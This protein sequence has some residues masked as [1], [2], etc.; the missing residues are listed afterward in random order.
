[1]NR[2][3][4]QS[5][6]PTVNKA[7]KPRTAWWLP[8]GVALA[9]GAAGAAQSARPPALPTTAVEREHAWAVHQE[10]RRDSPF[11]ALEWRAVGPKMVGGR[12]EA[13]AV[14][15]DNPATIYAGGAGNL[16]KTVN[17]G[18][19]WTPV[20]EHQEAFAIGDVAVA[21][22]NSDVVW[23]G[24]GE[25]Q[26]RFA[27][28]AFSGTGVYK[29]TDGGATWHNM[30]L[31]DT[32]HIPKVLIDPRNP[33]I[34][35]VS[36]MGHQ[37]STNAERG[38]FKTTD[39]G[40]TWTKVLYIDDSTGVIDMAM[41]PS[42]SAIVYAAAWHLPSG[43]QSAIYKTI[44]GG[45]TWKKLTNG[46][47]KGPLGRMG[48]DVAPGRPSVLYAFL[49]N[50]AKYEGAE[51]S[52]GR[53]VIGAELYRTDD[54]GEHWRRVNET[55]LYE[56]FTI[57]GWKFCDVRVSSDNPDDVYILGN[58]GYH[59]TDGGRTFSPFGEQILRLHDTEGKVL[60]LDQHEIWID[61]RNPNRVIVGNDGGL[62]MSYDRAH[63]WLHMNNLPI[64]QFY[65]VAT[66]MQQPYVIYGGTQ[67]DAAVYGPSDV[68]IAD[69]AA[70]L[71]HHV[72]L[73][74]WTGG[75]SFVTLPDPTDPNIVYYEHQNGDLRRMDITGSSVQT[76]RAAD[77]RPRAA[78]GEPEWRFGWYMPFV[79]S[80][81]NRE[82]LYAG[83]NKL[84]MSLDRGDHWQAISPDLSEPAG[85]DRAVV[86]YGTITMIGESSVKPGL[87]YVGTE[88]GAV[89]LTKNNGATWT[90]V[91]GDLPRKWVTRVIPSRWN[92]ATVYVGMSGYRTDDFRPYLYVSRDFGTTWR[93]IAANLPAESINVV[94]EDP[95]NPNVLY[96]GTDL[97]VYAS[98]D[99]G[100]SWVSLA[101][102]LPSTPVEDLVVHPRD[103]EIVIGTHGRG[104]F[105]LDARPVQQ[106]SE[107]TK[108]GLRLFAVRPTAVRDGDDIEPSRN[109]AE[110]RLLFYLQNAQPVTI[111]ITDPD[112]HV[113][114]KL[115]VEGHQGLNALVWDGQVEDRSS[116][117]GGWEGPMRLRYAAPGV[118]RVRI[119]AGPWEDGG[120]ITVTRYSRRY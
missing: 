18:I 63:T 104:V 113:V 21:S 92:P 85:G 51:P 1:M 12:V 38:V 7:R 17:N 55:D 20:F 61:P 32:H 112:R 62:F 115:T 107:A 67:D 89:W 116:P 34:V 94:R 13:V 109:R 60:H 100:G 57:Y 91:S 2:S 120:A 6:L 28:F 50:Q 59:S 35:Y 47:P 78:A 119:A 80:H 97:G 19:T 77:V 31:R 42:N 53:T 30:G 99:R 16:W 90:N 56:V 74:R 72:Y 79:I 73:D 22:S 49:D 69:A 25:V 98:L 23:V 26:P 44:D 29:S 4:P 14:A 105:V 36:A 88:A 114:R 66:D 33:D 83:G 95:R 96:V 10:L 103:D 84:L 41:D 58:R 5:Q 68:P 9:L 81:H 108:S 43:S 102:N 39:G 71:W 76:S 110:E 101:A 15:S 93:S 87:L 37:W 54:A 3:I 11:A 86:P 27:G 24:T 111:V 65:A 45:T 8:V 46:L 64:S 40:Q 106:W 82:T 117:G 75:D 70:D 118:Y 52:Q 48:L